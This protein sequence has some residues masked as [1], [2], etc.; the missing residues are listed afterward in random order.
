MLAT[1]PDGADSAGSDAD[2]VAGSSPSRRLAGT[3]GH[4]WR[5]SGSVRLTGCSV[6]QNAQVTATATRDRAAPGAVRGE[7]AEGVGLRKV[8]LIGLVAISALVVAAGR[9]ATPVGVV[10]E[11]SFGGLLAPSSRGGTFSAV[12]V[13]ISLAVLLACW[14]RVLRLALQR[15]VSLRAVGWTGATWLMPV[16]FAPPLLSL[17]AY[18]YLAQGTM[19]ATGLDP[20]SGGPVLL[21]DDPAAARVDPMWRASPVPYGPFTLLLLRAVALTHGNLA[22]GVL[23]LRGIAL[24]GVVAAVGAALRLAPAPRR[25][26]VLALCLLNPITLV[27]LIG[28][29][30]VDAVLAG[31]VGLSLLALRRDRP[32][33]AWLLASIAVAVKITAAPLLLFVLVV[34]WHQRRG[35]P[36]LVL[37]ATGLGAL[38]FLASLA[39]VSRPWGFLPALLV[40]GSVAPWYAP[41]TIAGNVLVGAGRLLALPVEP[42]AARLAGRLVVLL[43]GGLVVTALVRAEWADWAGHGSARGRATV[44]RAS[45]ALL[46]V[47]LCLPAIYGWYLAAGLFGLAAVGT[48]AWSA[49]IVALSSALTFS[50]LPPLYAASRWPLVVAWGVALT[51][52]G[53][54]Y[55]HAGRP[56]GRAGDLATMPEREPIAMGHLRYLR[57]AQAAGLG[58]IVPVTVGLLSPGASAGV[59]SEQTQSERARVVQQLTREYPRLQLG[60]VLPATDFGAP[61]R[62]ELV[63]PGERTCDLVLG[64]GIGPRVR[65]PRLPEDPI[66]RR[67]RAMDE[68]PCP[69]PVLPVEDPVSSAP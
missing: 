3:H 53:L 32:W 40:P 26:H 51:V 61:Y 65:F 66:E 1:F 17:D 62:V 6:R 64:P 59:A 25:P 31:V 35:W 23:L 43:L 10:L 33:L 30:H 8:A 16:L 67:V 19:L 69:L 38:P 14:W 39:A 68:R 18:A 5:R 13:V 21:G 58:L 37:A 55:K 12:A 57:L 50:S 54:A 45:T 29:A 15:R 41:A 42:S 48:P 27:H 9:A 4:V 60:S 44:Q 24:L 28:G 46:V 52:L 2:H 56:V 36:R 11:R 7:V 49:A 47:S 34:L 22:I 20:Y 63:R